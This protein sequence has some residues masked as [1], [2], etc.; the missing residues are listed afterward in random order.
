[1]LK[2]DCKKWVT[3]IYDTGSTDNTIQIIEQFCEDNDINLKLKQEEFINFEESRNKAI[4]FA[5]SIENIDY[6]LLLDS[7]D[8]LENGE[9]LL[10]LCI[11]KQ[12]TNETGF[13]LKQ[14]WIFV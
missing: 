8:I 11:E 1:V 13:Y 7:N 3:F 5:E 12:E 10:N 4:E 14:E 2:Y 9:E 6:L